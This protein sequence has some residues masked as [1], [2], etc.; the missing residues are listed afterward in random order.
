MAAGASSAAVDL[1]GLADP[2]LLPSLKAPNA[3][4]R[5]VL[6]NGGVAWL[7]LPTTLDGAPLHP[8]VGL[9]TVGAPGRRQLLDPAG[10]IALRPVAASADTTER[11]YRWLVAG[12]APRVALWDVRATPR[13]RELME[14]GPEAVAALARGPADSTRW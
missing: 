6:E 1:G 11:P 5:L 14:K 3:V 12:N 8:P 2:K 10:V 4:Q 13:G 7:A 9:R